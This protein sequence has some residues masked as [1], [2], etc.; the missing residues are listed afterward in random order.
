MNEP[1]LWLAGLMTLL[2]VATHVLKKIIEIRQ[3][4][5]SFHLKDYLT[6][7]PYQTSLIVIGALG[8]FFLL[9][10]INQLTYA[11]AF[12]MGFVANSVGEAAGKRSSTV[13][14]TK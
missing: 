5:D 3:A 8:G 7:Y 12:G 14:G 2:G 11:S 9:Q 4:D 1:N 6:K 13:M 10:E